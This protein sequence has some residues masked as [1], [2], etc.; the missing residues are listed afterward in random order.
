MVKKTPLKVLRDT[1]DLMHLLTGKRIKDVI[2]RAID[3]FG[4]EVI[5]KLVKDSPRR[6]PPDNPYR[7]LEVRPDASDFV[8]KAV[9]RAKVRVCHPDVKG[10]GN[11][12][13]FKRITAAF[14]QIMEQRNAPRE[15]R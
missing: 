15:D 14:E 12:E 8:V 5:R 4:E 9:Y 10:T 3:L 7:I 1:D 13:E 11:A 2:P 6:L